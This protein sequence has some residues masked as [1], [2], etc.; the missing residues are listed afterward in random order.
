MAG[1][2]GRPSAIPNA[3]AA[4]LAHAERLAAGGRF[5]FLAVQLRWLEVTMLML[6]SHP[7]AEQA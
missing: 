3:A 5:A 6:P 1:Q 7:A 2:P 4:C